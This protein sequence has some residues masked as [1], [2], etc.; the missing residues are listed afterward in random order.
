MNILENILP[1]LKVAQA[2]VTGN[3][4]PGREAVITHVVALAEMVST[5]K[6]NMDE[7]PDLIKRLKPLTEIDAAGCSDG[8]EQCLDMLKEKLKPHTNRLT[9]LKR[10]SKIKQF[11]KG[12]KYERE[13]QGIKA[14]IASHIQ[15]FTFHNSILIK[16]VLDK[17]S[18]KGVEEH[19]LLI[20]PPQTA[21]NFVPVEQNP[22]SVQEIASEVRDINNTVKD[23]NNTGKYKYPFL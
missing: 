12:K 3:P 7:L 22:K 6:S 16:K 10:K 13:I 21:S 15:D 11:F 5:M 1:V 14:S 17:M 9:S 4:V 8:L 19:F 23:V 20:I 2:A 18:K